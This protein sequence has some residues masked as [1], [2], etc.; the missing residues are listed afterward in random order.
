VILPPFP[1]IDGVSNSPVPGGVVHQLPRDLRKAL[2]ARSTA[3]DAWNDIT[4]LARN[5]FICWVEDAKQ[6]VTRV[7]RIRRT[8]EELDEG[9]RRP[10]CWPGCMHRE[11]NG[12]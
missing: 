12:R 8:L 11:R 6:D 2:I 4:P 1:K 3:L 5:E 9:Q 10:C 7:R